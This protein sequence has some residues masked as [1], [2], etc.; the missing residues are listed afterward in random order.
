MLKCMAWYMLRG[1]YGFG[2]SSQRGVLGWRIYRQKKPLRSLSFPFCSHV[3][4]WKEGWMTGPQICNI[5]IPLGSS[6]DLPLVRTATPSKR[7]IVCNKLALHPKTPRYPCNT[8]WHAPL[9]SFNGSI[10]PSDNSHLRPPDCPLSPFP[11][12]IA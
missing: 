1:L 6:H 2:F 12:G 4:L 5:C 3:S 11:P 10:P 7:G 9:I 8:G